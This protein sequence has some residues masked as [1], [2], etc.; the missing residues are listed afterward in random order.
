MRQ[1]DAVCVVEVNPVQRR[2]G[3]L[4]EVMP[5][6]GLMVPMRPGGSEYLPIEQSGQLGQEAGG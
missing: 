6:T 3:F 5:S 2:E 1:P 4:R